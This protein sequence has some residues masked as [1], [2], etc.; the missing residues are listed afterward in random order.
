MD[1]MDETG[2]QAN[3]AIKRKSNEA[4]DIAAETYGTSSSAVLWNDPQTQYLRFHELVRYLD[5][6][7]H[8]KTLLDIGC[9]NGELFKFLNFMGFRGSYT[10]Y[11]I[12]EKLLAHAKARFSDIDVHHK[13]ILTDQ[14]LSPQCFDYVVMSGLFNLNV[15]QSEAWVHEFL[16]KMFSLCGE[17][18]VCNMIS[19]HVSYRDN[20]LFYLDPAETLAYCIKNLSKRT[21]LAHHNL[22]YN[23]TICVY[24]NEAWCSAR[25]MKP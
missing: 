3:D 24:R 8:K 14:S 6:N 23:Y 21:T 25:E 10:G 2:L 12:N 13:D 22:P 9:G 7:D 17:L 16:K 1:Q 15:G 4:F 11:D 18:M 19:T 20:D 5:L